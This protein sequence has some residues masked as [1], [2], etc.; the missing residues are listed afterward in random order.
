MTSICIITGS[1]LGGAEYVADHI[2]EVLS[3]QGFEVELFNQATL[4]DIE[5][6]TNLIIVTS[7]HGAGELP[8]NIQQL[9]DDLANSSADFSSMKFG[10]IGL[11][12]SDY[13]TFCNAVNIVEEAL[14]A[15][16]ASQVC[17]SL[18]IDVMN[19]FDHDGSAEE[20]LPSFVEQL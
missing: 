20:W 13:D 12:S 15:K 17:E 10:V 6:K 18:R 14:K 11:G 19:N 9:F 8:E 4:A 5:G 3:E 7:T 1:T 2:N 16:G